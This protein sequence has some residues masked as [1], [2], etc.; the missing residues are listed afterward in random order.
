[1]DVAFRLPDDDGIVG[2]TDLLVRLS[3]ARQPR[4][5]TLYA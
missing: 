2:N 4:R 3:G 1:V 5:S